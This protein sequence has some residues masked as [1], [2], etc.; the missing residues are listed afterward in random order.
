[1][2]SNERIGE[3]FAS[4]APMVGTDDLQPIYEACKEAEV[5][6]VLPV[7]ERDNQGGQR[8]HATASACCRAAPSCSSTFGEPAACAVRGHTG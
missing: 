6:V 5:N 1:M 7:T 8:R 3:L 4:N 2:T